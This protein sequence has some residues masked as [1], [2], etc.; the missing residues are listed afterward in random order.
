[1][2][3]APL[4]RP[5]RRFPELRTLTR[6]FTGLAGLLVS[7]F[8]ASAL[9]CTLTDDG[10]KPEQVVN[11]IQVPPPAPAKDAGTAAVLEAGT[12]GAEGCCNTDQECAPTERCLGGECARS[13]C[14]AEDPSGCELVPCSGPD[15]TP[16]ATPTVSCADGVQNGDETDRDCGG[17]CPAR[18]TE[19]LGCASNADCSTSLFCAPESGRCTPAECDDG[20]QNGAEILIDCGGGACPGCPDGTA[21]E[22]DADCLNQVCAS[23]GLCAAPSC[24]DGRANQNETDVD[25]GGACP[26]NCGVGA[27]CSAAADCESRVCEAIGCAPGL[28]RCCQAP[29]CED[30]IAN[31]GEPVVDCGNATC[32]LCAEGDRCTAG[33][34]CQGGTCAAG[35]C[36]TPALCANGNR[37]GA[38]TDVDCGGPNP[39]CNRCADRRACQADSDCA[40]ANCLDGVC[41]SCG[42]NVQ[43]GTETDVDCGGA[44]PACVR[45]LDQRRCLQ[46]GDCANSNCDNFRC[47]SCGSGIQDGTETDVDCGG[48]D[49]FCRRCLPFER[50][51]VAS[52]CQNFSCN[53]GVCG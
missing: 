34:Q 22:V 16:D 37:D 21:C 35:A 52:D 31:G 8:F 29:T 53:A 11:Q 7:G 30:G 32:G 9:S 47:I 18:C 40:N 23:D 28:A 3:S 43:D 38:E 48:A 17:T 4:Q 24:T 44:D 51:V 33:A 46:A 15:C 13:S 26:E 1:M 45:C 14:T 39:A 50:C 10:F 19:S 6:C 36:F 49:P 2:S 42:D 20:L 27:G 5:H 12:C 25:C 41:I